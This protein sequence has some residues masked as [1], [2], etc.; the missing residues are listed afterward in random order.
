MF[1][2]YF[3]LLIWRA[4]NLQ[5][6]VT[7]SNQ[8][9]SINLKTNAVNNKAY[10]K[11]ITFLFDPFCHFIMAWNENVN[12]HYLAAPIVR[13]HARFIN[14]MEITLH[15]LQYRTMQWYIIQNENANSFYLAAKNRIGNYPCR[16]YFWQ[17]IPLSMTRTRLEV[18]LYGAFPLHN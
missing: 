3:N 6:K 14:R 9:L 18:I 11:N 15:G 12:A 13:M 5:Q 17:S 8:I 4:R 10:L 2:W 1:T 16:K 7:R